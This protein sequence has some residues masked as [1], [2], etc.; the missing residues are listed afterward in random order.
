MGAVGRSSFASGS[1]KRRSAEF[2]LVLVR[3]ALLCTDPLTESTNDVLTGMCCA[4]LSIFRSSN[5][6]QMLIFVI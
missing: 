2:Y 1:N 6:S 5:K 4:P 3:S